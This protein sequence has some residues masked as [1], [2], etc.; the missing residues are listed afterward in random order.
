[1]FSALWLPARFYCFRFW[2]LQRGMTSMICIFVFLNVVLALVY[3]QYH[4]RSE[5]LHDQISYVKKETLV[6]AQLALSQEQKDIVL[7]AF[8]NAKLI[9]VV[10]QVAEES[11]MPV[12]EITYVLDANAGQPF[13]RYHINLSVDASYPVVRH[14]VEQLQRLQPQISLDGISCRKDDIGVK[15]LNCDLSLSAFYRKP[16]G[17]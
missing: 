12:D 10:H 17:G 11:R 14:F 4:Y 1:M 5:T 3:G 8:D 7:P 9:A 2:R 16:V 6:R 13:F 15:A